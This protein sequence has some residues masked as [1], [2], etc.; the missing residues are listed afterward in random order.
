MLA[1]ACSDDRPRAASYDSGRSAQPRSAPAPGSTALDVVPDAGSDAAIGAPD[2]GED[3]AVVVGE[4]MATEQLRPTA[5]HVAGDSLYWLLDAIGQ[6]AVMKMAI[7]GGAPVAVA[8]GLVQPSS[9]QIDASA[10]YWIAYGDQAGIHK[11][12]LA[13]GPTT[14]LVSSSTPMPIQ[15]LA[16]DATHV[17]FSDV[18]DGSVKKVD[19][20]GGPTVTVH[21][22]LSGP[23]DLAIDELGVYVIES[24]DSGAIVR[25]PL[26]GGAPVTLASAQP[27]PRGLLLTETHVYWFNGGAF[28]GVTQTVIGAAVMRAPKSGG[29]AAAIAPTEGVSAIAVDDASIWIAVDDAVLRAPVTGGEALAV[30]PMQQHPRSVA[31]G[32]SFIYWTNAGTPAEGFTDGSVRRLAK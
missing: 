10:A 32:G 18:A 22:G 1:L 6:G 24:G 15:R 19:K 4:L 23:T 27:D 9:L 8:K 28:D 3:A 13:G 14:Q 25:L 20:G 12:P 2:A 11:V 29:A 5:L 16:L 30:A 31:T 17:Y 21:A 26:D 7:G